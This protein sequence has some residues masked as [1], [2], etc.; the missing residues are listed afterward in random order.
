MKNLIKLF[1]ILLSVS[2]SFCDIGNRTQEI[3]QNPDKYSND[4]KR[5]NHIKTELQSYFSSLSEPTLIKNQTFK[6]ANHY[7]DATLTII[8]GKVFGLSKTDI[9]DLKF[10]MNG[11]N[12]TFL[13]NFK[14]FVPHLFTTNN[15][16][17]IEKKLK[18]SRNL[19]G[20]FNITAGKNLQLF[21]SNI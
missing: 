19:N 8:T 12:R 18:P 3:D 6:Q 21:F 2:Q 16:N 7:F 4:P 15:F 14:F 9:K 1:F 5:D 20:I 11:K 17:I 13:I 10:S